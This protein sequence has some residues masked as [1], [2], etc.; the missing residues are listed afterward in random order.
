MDNTFLVSNAGVTYNPAFLAA[1]T[2][3]SPVTFSWGI[4]PVAGT[5]T[6]IAS[7]TLTGTGSLRVTYDYTPFQT[8]APVPEPA[9]GLV[10]AAGVAALV[11]YRR[12]RAAV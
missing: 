11:G 10:F 7:G 4:G 6:G 8:E 5:A 12:R 2:G 3:G 9:T 1:V